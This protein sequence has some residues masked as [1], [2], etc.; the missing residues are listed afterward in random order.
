MTITLT[1]G[2]QLLLEKHLKTGLYASVDDLI[3]AALQALD[4]VG[5]L[6]EETLDAI[7]IAEAEFER[8]EALDWDQV[9][10]MIRKE[11]KG[12]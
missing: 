11:F 10:D 8:G 12:G 9:K 5:P 7:D 4:A 6:D 1:P 2:T 3:V